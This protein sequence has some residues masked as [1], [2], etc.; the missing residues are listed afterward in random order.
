MLTEIV[1]LYFIA[2]FAFKAPRFGSRM[3]SSRPVAEEFLSQL[4]SS[5]S[6]SKTEQIKLF[7]AHCKEVERLATDKD[8]LRLSM[9]LQLQKQ[10]MTLD[11]ELQNMTLS[12]ELQLQKLNMTLHMELELLKVNM[13]NQEKT[14]I[15][16]CLQ[17]KGACTSRG[18]LE[19]P[20]SHRVLEYLNAQRPAVDLARRFVIARVVVTSL[21]ATAIQQS[22]C[23]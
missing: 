2:A 19:Y 13:A 21:E 6:L 20:F 5:N 15:K 8:E 17:A 7:E 4:L 16:E 14:L 3:S 10:N 12:M 23:N 1:F 22:S 9:E 18:I 11:M